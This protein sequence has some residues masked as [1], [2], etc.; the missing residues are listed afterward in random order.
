MT[1]LNEENFKKAI[2]DADLAQFP[3]FTDVNDALKNV[4]SVHHSWKQQGPSLVC[5]SCPHSHSQWVGMDKRLTG[6][7]NEGR[8]TLEVV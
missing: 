6:F 1:D 5:S 7:D 2:K 8:P 4:P 3:D